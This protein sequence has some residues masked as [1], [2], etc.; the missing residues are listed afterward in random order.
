MENQHHFWQF[1]WDVFNNWAGYFTGG[2][3]MAVITFWHSWREKTMRRNYLI[4]ITVLFFAMGAYKAWE[5]Q[6]EKAVSAESASSSY[7]AQTH[8]CL[9]SLKENRHTID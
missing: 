5:E 3:V 9:A 4:V 8:E 6:Y 2:L 1:A 7:L